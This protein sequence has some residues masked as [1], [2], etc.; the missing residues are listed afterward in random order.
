MASLVQFF[1]PLSVEV[2]QDAHESVTNGMG[3][4]YLE[5]STTSIPPPHFMIKQGSDLDSTG[6]PG[7]PHHG[8]KS[9]RK[10]QDSDWRSNNCLV[11]ALHVQLT[12][13]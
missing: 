4:F 7:P 11:S 2:D 12:Y 13:P 9:S 8:S 10:F 3:P 5:P 6:F 1:T